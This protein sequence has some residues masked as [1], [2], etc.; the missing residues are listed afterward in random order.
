MSMCQNE[1]ITMDN[2]TEAIQIVTY[3][4]QMLQARRD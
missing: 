4:T 1:V 3:L 2:L